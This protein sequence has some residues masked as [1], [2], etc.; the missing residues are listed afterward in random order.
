EL[1]DFL[2]QNFYQTTFSFASRNCNNLAHVLAHKGCSMNLYDEL[3]ADNVTADVKALGAS[4]SA[5]ST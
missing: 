3:N 4:E 1:K 2:S 5:S